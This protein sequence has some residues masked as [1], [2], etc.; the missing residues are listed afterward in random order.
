MTETVIHIPTLETERLRLRAPE[1]RDFEAY[2]DYCAGD[3]SRTVGGPFDRSAA[4]DRFCALIGHWQI[5]GY[6]R[7]IVADRATDAALGLS[8]LFRPEGWPEPEIAWTVFDH[9]EG[10]G[11]AFEAAKA[12]RAHAY[13]TLGWS[14]VMS[15]IDPENARSIALA[16]RMGCTPEGEFHHPVYGRLGI[17]RHVAPAEIKESV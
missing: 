14:T 10:R 2:A 4:F 5:R 11:V 17:W 13:E 3:R 1:Q 15:A 16:R 12:V 7:W 8:G 6:G 9:A